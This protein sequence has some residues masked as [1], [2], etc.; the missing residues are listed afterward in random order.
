MPG[1]HP[2][3]PAP[4]PEEVS[5]L[6]T[7]EAVHPASPLLRIVC[8]VVGLLGLVMVA[9]IPVLMAVNLPKPDSPARVVAIILSIVFLVCAAG[10]LGWAVYSRG[11]YYAAFADALVR[12][13]RG[14]ATVFRWDEIKAV[15]ESFRPAGNKYWITRKDGQRLTLDYR[16]KNVN[17]L[18]DLVQG[19]VTERLLPA[20][21]RTFE[22]GGT[23]SFGALGVSRAALSNKGKQLAWGDVDSFSI[24][25]IPRARMTQLRVGQKGKVLPWCM[26]NTANVPNLRLF[27]ELVRRACPGC[28]R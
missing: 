19:R 18:G 5:S 17:A 25:Y 14:R 7:P 23:V 16:I 21:L 10:L 12:V 8:W 3:L 27:L 9:G 26:V 28:L 13:H 1:Q 4:L 2:E 11:L 6:G 20:A 24:Q 22:E 15:R